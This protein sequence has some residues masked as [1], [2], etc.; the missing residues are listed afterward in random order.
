MPEKPPFWTDSAGQIGQVPIMIGQDINTAGVDP[1]SGQNAHALAAQIVRQNQ[2]VINKFVRVQ[3]QA[4]TV[5]GLDVHSSVLP[6]Q[7]MEVYYSYVQG[8]ERMHYHVSPQAEA[9]QPEPS[10]SEEPAKPIP[11]EVPQFPEPKVPEPET[12]E[13]PEPPEVQEPELKEPE[14]PEEEKPEEEEKK[15]ELG[16]PD[17]LGIDLVLGLAVEF[18]DGAGDP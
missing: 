1:A 2:P 16:H 8:L 10:P 7:D 11:P 15:E 17:F 18:G 13:I 3:R 5:G 4:I 14:L 9:P 6:L 12:P